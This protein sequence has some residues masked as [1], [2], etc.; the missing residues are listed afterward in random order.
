LLNIFAVL[1]AIHKRSI[2][3]KSSENFAERISRYL[4]RKLTSLESFVINKPLYALTLVVSALVLFFLAMRRAMADDN[5]TDSREHRP[6]K[7][8]RLD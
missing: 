1:D 6:G 3:P 2:T 8:R 7:S 4:N 5:F